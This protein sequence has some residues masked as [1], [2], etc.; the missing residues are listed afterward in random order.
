M[1]VECT[2]G[3]FFIQ[4]LVISSHKES[5]S[6]LEHTKKV[7]VTDDCIVY[8]HVAKLLQ[9]WILHRVT[10]VQIL[11]RSSGADERSQCARP[12]HKLQRQARVDRVWVSHAP[13]SVW[14]CGCYHGQEKS[15]RGN[16]R[17]FR[18]WVLYWCYFQLLDAVTT[19]ELWGIF[20]FEKFVKI[21]S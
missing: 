1:L 17:G 6:F 7:H 20:D 19:A 16:R 13:P 10:Y 2:T 15:T 4:L 14:D 8:M 5:V 3:L 11:R 21:R 12:H 18:R 9:S